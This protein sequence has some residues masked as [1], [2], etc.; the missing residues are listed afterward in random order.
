MP[1]LG[2]N[3]IAPAIDNITIIFAIELLTIKGLKIM[4]PSKVRQEARRES[5]EK[6]CSSNPKLSISNQV[7][8]GPG[9][10]I[11]LK[12]NIIIAVPKIVSRIDSESS[13]INLAIRKNI[14]LTDPMNTIS[15]A[16]GRLNPPT[17]SV[18]ITKTRE[19]PSIHQSTLVFSISI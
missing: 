18:K 10:G 15:C 4:M 17:L 7:R 14:I 8:P 11:A 12:T 1:T 5:T 9:P 19:P 6:N 16:Y 2:K 3:N 13:R